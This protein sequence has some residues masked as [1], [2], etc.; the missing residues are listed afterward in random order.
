VCSK[1]RCRVG[2][3]PQGGVWKNATCSF[4]LWTAGHSCQNSFGTNAD[5]NAYLHRR[6]SLPG[7]GEAN[8]S[9]DSEPGRHLQ[10][11]RADHDILSL[12]SVDHDHFPGTGSNGTYGRAMAFLGSLD[13][14]DPLWIQQMR[15]ISMFVFTRGAR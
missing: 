11:D 5:R 15:A 10:I 6:R 1:S 2:L 12:Q 4:R 13:Q 8:A 9:G 7:T 3:A 14:R